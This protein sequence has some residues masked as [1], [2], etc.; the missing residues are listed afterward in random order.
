[1]TKLISFLCSDVTDILTPENVIIPSGGFFP[2]GHSDRVSFFFLWFFGHW[3]HAFKI[4]FSWT[5]KDKFLFDTMTFTLLVSCFFDTLILRS[6][7]FF[8]DTLTLRC[9]I[10][11]FFDTLTL[12]SLIL[13]FFDTLTLTCFILCFFDILTLRCFVLCFI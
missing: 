8:C 12:E 4:L 1:M 7:I 2:N 5:V 11:C 6:W 13:C 3:H 10:L 9:L